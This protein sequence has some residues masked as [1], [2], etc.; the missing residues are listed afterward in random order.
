[1]IEKARYP[2]DLNSQQTYV[3]SLKITYQTYIDTWSF[4]IT[5]QTYI[6]SL[7]IILQPSNLDSSQI[8]QKT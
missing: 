4:Q 2:V 8:I 5:Q 7:H 3:D 6:D 1:M